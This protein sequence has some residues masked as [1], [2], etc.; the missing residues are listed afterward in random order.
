[1]GMDWIKFLV[2]LALRFSPTPW[3]PEAI[4]PNIAAGAAVKLTNCAH[5]MAM[6]RIHTDLPVYSL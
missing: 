6:F 3:E 2:V 1:M 5:L 4:C